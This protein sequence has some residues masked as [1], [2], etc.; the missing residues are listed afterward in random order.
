MHICLVESLLCEFKGMK[1]Y[2]I[3]YIEQLD[4]VFQFQTVPPNDLCRDVAYHDPPV[5][6]LG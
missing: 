6:V 1:I 3:D 2:P 5:T 4:N